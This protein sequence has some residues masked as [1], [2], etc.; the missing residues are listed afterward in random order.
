MPSVSQ[1]V[2]LT[3]P[4]ASQSGRAHAYSSA[5]TA[6]LAGRNSSFYP[7]AAAEFGV[8]ENVDYPL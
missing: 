6:V 3:Q 2:V 7:A 8:L 4:A 1:S 5:L